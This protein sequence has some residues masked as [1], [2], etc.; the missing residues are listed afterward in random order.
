MTVETALARSTASIATEHASR[1]LQQLC[2]HFAHKR[3]VTFTPEQGQITLGAGECRLAAEDG[4]LKLALEAADE[5]QLAQLQ[6]VV[7][8][9][10]VRFAFREDLKV[11]WKPA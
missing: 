1:Y 8:R 9:H 11:A 2:K 10:L 6:D 5:A 4:A 7:V 3:P